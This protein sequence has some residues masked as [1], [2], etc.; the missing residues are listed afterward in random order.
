M[1]CRALAVTL[2]T[3]LALGCHASRP[4]TGVRVQ[5]FK[6]DDCG[7]S[8]YYDQTHALNS[9]Y[10]RIY[11]SQAWADCVPDG[12]NAT[13]KYYNGLNCSGAPQ[14]VLFPTAPR[15]SQGTRLF[16]TYD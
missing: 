2:L 13:Q 12:G 9:C 3:V 15:C 14:L 7:G 16:C 4:V 11:Y 10:N 6:T 1:L 5:F 8:P